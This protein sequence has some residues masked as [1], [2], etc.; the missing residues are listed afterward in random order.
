MK[1]YASF[2]E[3]IR[4]TTFAM[5]TKAKVIHSERWQAVAIADR[6]EMAMHVVLNHSFEVKMRSLDLD[7]LR[8]Q[9][10]P[11]LPWADD[12]FDERVCGQ[13]LNPGKTWQ[14]WPWGH[15]A[16]KFRDE[17]GR[18]NHNYMERYWPKLAGL[19]DQGELSGTTYDPVYFSGRGVEEEAAIGVA[20]EQRER[21]TRQGIRHPYGDLHDLVQLFVKEP[22]TRQGYLPIWF[23]ED[24]GNIH[25]GR[26][27]CTLGYL[28]DLIENKFNV[29]Y[30]IRSCDFRRHFRDDIYLTVRLLRWVMEQCAAEDK[31]WRDVEPGLFTMHCRNLHV[32]RNDY[33]EMFGG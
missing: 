27:P 33:R 17:H 12:H 3:A 14:S 8:R 10:V 31:R 30:Y 16:D 7:Y 15:S 28:F 20:R 4:D 21:D 2:G 25:D 6:P 13:P 22:S 23:P 5:Q 19:T 24:T 29:T 9:I 11:N 1:T 26:K 32:F 18:F